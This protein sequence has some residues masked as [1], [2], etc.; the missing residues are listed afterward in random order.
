[1]PIVVMTGKEYY[2]PQLAVP[3]RKKAAYLER[4]N[5]LTDDERE[6]LPVDAFEPVRYFE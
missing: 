6:C 2:R 4:F 1:M 3:G 5:L